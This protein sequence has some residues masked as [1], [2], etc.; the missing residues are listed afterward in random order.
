VI[1]T[2]YYLGCLAHGS[3]LIADESSGEAAVV[4]PQRD[5]DQYVQDARRLSCRIGHVFL[6]HF[7][8][9]FLSGHLELRDREAQGCT[10]GGR[11]RNGG[12][13]VHPLGDHDSVELDFLGTP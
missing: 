6:S 3:Y 4:D 8:A 13:R 7:H 1:L 5:V 10:P 9:D 12:V 11:T 2:Q